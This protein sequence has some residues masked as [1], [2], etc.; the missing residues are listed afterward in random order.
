MEQAIIGELLGLLMQSAQKRCY[1][2]IYVT[3]DEKLTT[4]FCLSDE[5]ITCEE[6]SRLWRLK[7]IAQFIQI[8]TPDDVKRIFPEILLCVRSTIGKTRRFALQFVEQLA[9]LGQLVS[10]GV[11]G[12][13]LESTRVSSL[14]LLRY[15]APKIDDSAMKVKLLQ[16]VLLLSDQEFQAKEVNN[17]ILKYIKSSLHGIPQSDL[18]SLLPGLMERVIRYTEAFKSKSRII[19]TL[20]LGLVGYDALDRVF[21][22]KHKAL[23]HYITKT[24]KKKKKPRTKHHFDREKDDEEKKSKVYTKREAMPS[25]NHFLH[26]SEIPRAAK[27]RVIE[28][29]EEFRM[30]FDN[31]MV[32]SEP[33][34]AP[35]FAAK[36]ERDG[37]TT[38][39]PTKKRKTTTESGVVVTQAGTDYKAKKAQG[40]KQK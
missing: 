8:L 34:A 35:A 30:N 5:I 7:C 10:M 33:T 27:K 36:R 14:I 4:K 25:E 17:C 28:A 39:A 19:V 12:L 9:D 15:L 1:K 2:L 21:P 6:K 40:D 26:P 38:D 13:A 22:E 11:T 37:P 31:R 20:L 29:E 24:S 16:T 23:L 18:L 3:K 32:I